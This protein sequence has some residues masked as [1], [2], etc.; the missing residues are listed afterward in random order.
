MSSHVVTAAELGGFALFRG[1]PEAERVMIAAAASRRE[2][3]DGDVL[4]A[5]GAPALEMFL[6][7]RGQ[8]TLRVVRDGR[9]VIVGALGPG[10]VLGWSCLRDEPVSLTTARASGPVRL[11]A[12]PAE[13]LLELVSSGSP[14]GRTTMRR[15]FG[16]AAMHLAAAREQMIR[17]GREGVITAG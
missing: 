10:E 4:Y 11:V 13:A 16:V 5:E 7:E 1:L 15:L 14:A 2:P 17:Q 12:I 6:V 8:I 3:A 9:P